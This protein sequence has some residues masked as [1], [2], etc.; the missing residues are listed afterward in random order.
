MESSSP[1][2]RRSR[3][4][5]SA[6]ALAFL[7]VAAAALGAFAVTRN[8]VEENEDRL[9]RERAAE[10][11]ALLHNSVESS[12]STLGLVA[13]LATLPERSGFQQ[14]AGALARGLGGAVVALTP[15][16]TGF[17]VTAV[18]AGGP[19]A[20][21]QPVG[22]DVASLAAR[23]LQS[24]VPA[25][26]LIGDGSET[27]LAFAVAAP[28]P[29]ATVAVLLTQID[30][31]RPLPRTDGS[32]FSEMS[33]A[34]YAAPT[35]DPARLV[36][37]SEQQLPLSGEVL[38]VPFEV[39]GERWTLAVKAR[40]SLIG[41]FAAAAPWIVLGAGLLAALLTGAVVRAIA[42]RQDYAEALVEERSCELRS[43]QE[44]LERLL[45]SGP[46]VVVRSDLS[47]AGGRVSYVSPNVERIL[48]L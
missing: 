15:A 16:E 9:L 33:G 11:S 47:E 48:G 22:G 39:G 32:A 36:L 42:R 37:T 29:A 40:S 3:P 5:V 28:P 4:G 20:L 14:G 18:T 34:L 6:A 43:T 12:F 13:V 44:F 38:E 46:A 31:R 45:I 30:P 7:I 26:D 19:M 41:D 25:V 2:S 10:V 17:S 21:G 27:R 35:A 1:S 8:V 23:A 24:R